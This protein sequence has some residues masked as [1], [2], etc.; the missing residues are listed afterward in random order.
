[1]GKSEEGWDQPKGGGRVMIYEPF[2]RAIGRQHAINDHLIWV[3]SKRVGM[4]R[5]GTGA[6]ILG[7]RLPCRWLRLWMLPGETPLAPRLPTVSSAGASPPSRR[8]FAWAWP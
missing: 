4:T 8:N 6:A 7:R 1:M 2:A 3:P 5:G